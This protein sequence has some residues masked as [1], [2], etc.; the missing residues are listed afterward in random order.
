MYS[1]VELTNTLV[2][3]ALDHASGT[4]AGKVRGYVSTAA[5]VGDLAQ[6]GWFGTHQGANNTVA[7]MLQILKKLG[8]VDQRVAADVPEGSR[9]GDRVGPTSGPGG[10]NRHHGQPCSSY[11]LST[12][13]ANSVISASASAS[14]NLRKRGSA[15]A[16]GSS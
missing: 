13:V 8:Y 2:L 7:Y 3:T 9:A 15:S 6:L 16:L 10:V 5:V 11:P 4:A 1:P 12:R 14:A